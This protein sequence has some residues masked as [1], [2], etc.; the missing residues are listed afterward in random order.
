MFSKCVEKIEELPTEPVT[1]SHTNQSV[2]VR[3]NYTPT[4][5]GKRFDFEVFV[6]FSRELRWVKA[7]WGLAFAR[8]SI[9]KYTYEIRCQ[10]Q[11]IDIFLGQCYANTF[12]KCYD[13]AVDLKRI[14]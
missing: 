10:V 3:T 9:Q 4:E 11:P 1:L 6:V 13:L 14:P 7:W 8:P 12:L 5:G 2:I